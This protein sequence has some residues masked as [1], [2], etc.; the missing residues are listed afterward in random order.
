MDSPV[1]R[2]LI[3]PGIYRHFKGGLYEVRDT[4]IHSETLETYVYYRP[5]DSVVWWI[6]PYA[7]FCSQV[8]HQG[9][10]VPRF[11]LVKSNSGI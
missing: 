11:E 2:K 10:M 9:R 6:R 7:M 8:E 4:V 3:A 5:E 1:E